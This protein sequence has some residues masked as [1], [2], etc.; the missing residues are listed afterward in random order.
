[1]AR[2]AAAGAQRA[3]RSAAAFSQGGDGLLPGAR[4]SSPRP[5]WESSYVFAELRR[6][7]TRVPADRP[8][9][10]RSSSERDRL[11]CPFP[12][13]RE[14]QARS[15]E[16]APE[17]AIASPRTIVGSPGSSARLWISPLAPSA[18]G[19]RGGVNSRLAGAT[20]VL[21]AGDRRGA[22]PAAPTP[23]PAEPTPAFTSEAEAFAAAEETY[24]AYVDALNAVDLSDPE[25]FEDVY[26]WTTGDANAGDRETFS[27]M[28]ADGGPSRGQLS[29]ALVAT[30]VGGACDRLDGV[31]LDVCLDVSDVDAR[32]RGRQLGRRR[33]PPRRPSMLVTRHMSSADD[34]T[35]FSSIESIG[36]RMA[37]PL[38]TRAAIASLARS[39]AGS[40]SQCIRRD[41]SA[42]SAA[43]HVDRRAASRTPARRSTSAPASTTPGR[44]RGIATTPSPRRAQPA[45]PAPA[46]PADCPLDRCDLPYDVVAPPDVTLADLASFRPAQPEP[47][48]RARRASVSSGMP[49]NVMAVGIRAAHSGNR[50]RLGRHGP[51]R[52]RRLRVRL[53]R[54]RHRDARRPAARAGSG[55]GR[56]SSHRPRRAMST[57]SA[58]RIRC[59]S[60]CSTRHPSISAREPGDRSR[61]T[62]PS[63]TGGYD[64]RVVEVRTALVDKT[65]AENPRGPGC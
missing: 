27:Q 6:R 20:L 46:D 50:A 54:R 64:V 36:S 15:P 35:G 44:R 29:I 10:R 53:R 17:P 62:S 41:C 19:Y 39:A 32:R 63:T 55:S 30:V 22:P 42:V 47:R 56:R 11:S 12:H 13:G 37:S 4:R 49:T 33:R 7:G 45:A 1:M 40:P 24:R 43:R 65:C 51:L 31:A 9:S 25:T 48:R 14:G 16:P 28:H 5:P 23:E 21:A 34:P 60:T 61:A 52:A 2:E 58:A 18:R 26:A 59:R 38:A 8:A 57:A 3:H